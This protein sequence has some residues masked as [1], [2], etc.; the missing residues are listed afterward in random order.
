MKI[1]LCRHGETE[2]SL[3]G[4][5]TGQKADIG[6]TPHGKKEAVLLKERL[7][8]ESFIKVFTSPL[9]R[10]METSAGM[11]AI[12]EPLLKEWDYGEYEGKMSKE[13]GPGWNLFRDGAPGGESPQQV[14]KRADQMLKKL[15]SINGNVVLFSHAH[16]LR[17]LAAR[18]L[19]LNVAEGQDFLLS[20]GSLSILGEEKG[21]KAI[22]LWNEVSH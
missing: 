14:G 19:G 15:A 17:V 3:S 8:K 6:L 16:F 22:L 1:F 12:V 21:Q 11:G 5:H 20:T 4:R 13:I 10:A 9:R 18:Y 7:K 2:W